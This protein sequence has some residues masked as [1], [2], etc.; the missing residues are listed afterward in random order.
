MASEEAPLPTICPRS[1]I[2]LFKIP[3][4]FESVF[5]YIKNSCVHAQLFLK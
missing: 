2:T 5:T 1:D 4:A 3:I